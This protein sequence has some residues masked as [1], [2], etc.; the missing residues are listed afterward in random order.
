MANWSRS[1]MSS[2]AI[3]PADAPATLYHDTRSSAS[4]GRAMSTAQAEF[5]DS[6]V[7]A[8]VVMNSRAFNRWI[9][10]ASTRLS[11]RVKLTSLD[12][13]DRYNKAR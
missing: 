9:R 1:L 10:M 13:S 6:N 11:V 7:A 4:R 2:L 5:F 3:S 8:D 12:A